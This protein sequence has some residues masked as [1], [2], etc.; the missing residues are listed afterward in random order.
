MGTAQ[1]TLS[2]C[3]FL[4]DTGNGSV[5]PF[6]RIIHTTLKVYLITLRVTDSLSEHMG[7]N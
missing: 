7:F 2:L 3:R 1:A 6:E 4:L 5:V